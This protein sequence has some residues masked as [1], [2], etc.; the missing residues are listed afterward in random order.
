M[1]RD[2]PTLRVTMTPATMRA[3]RLDQSA[4]RGL[5]THGQPGSQS[6]RVFHTIAVSRFAHVR[7]EDARGVF[8][9]AVHTS[10]ELQAELNPTQAQD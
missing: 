2:W 9:V 10:A 1:C 8:P 4:F 7:P 6:N 5:A 3:V